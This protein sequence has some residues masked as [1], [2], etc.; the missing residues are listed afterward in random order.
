MN[1]QKGAFGSPG[2]RRPNWPPSAAGTSGATGSTSPGGPPT[3]R[4]RKD[5]R[6]GSAPLRPPKPTP[7]E[8]FDPLVISDENFAYYNRWRMH[9][10]LKPVARDAYE[11]AVWNQIQVHKQRVDAQEPENLTIDKVLAVKKQLL[12]GK[13]ISERLDR[14][15]HGQ[16]D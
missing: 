15:R 3:A 16:V 14:E 2:K 1:N 13:A 10:G 9:Q 4:R 7:P 12:A 6:T 8:N 11:R 5:G